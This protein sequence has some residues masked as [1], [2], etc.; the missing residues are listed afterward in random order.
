[1][2][3]ERLQELRK[4]RRLSQKELAK[5]LNLS[6]Y[7]ISS[8]ERNCSDPNDE[9]K[10]KIAKLLNVSLDYLLG[11]TNQCSSYYHDED[12]ILVSGLT[13]EEKQ[14][15]KDYRDFLLSKRKQTGAK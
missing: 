1:M 5:K 12:V 13:A 8:Y 3:G 4:D 14:S 9:D 6:P 7:T 15:V 2:I 11:L 10:I